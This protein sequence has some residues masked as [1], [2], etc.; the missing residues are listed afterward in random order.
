MID[1]KLIFIVLA[2]G[3]LLPAGSALP[4]SRTS[5]ILTQP[6]LDLGS[7]EEPNVADSGLEYSGIARRSIDLISLDRPSSA[8]SGSGYLD[9]EPLT[10]QQFGVVVG[11]QEPPSVGLEYPGT[12][13]VPSAA[14]FS[15]YILINWISTTGAAKG[16]SQRVGVD[17]NVVLPTGTP[18]CGLDNSNFKLETLSVPPGG[19]EVMGGVGAST[20][21]SCDYIMNIAPIMDYQGNP[22]T[23]GPG[24]Y[25]VVIRYIKDGKE[26]ASKNINFTIGGLTQLPPEMGLQ[27]GSALS[28]MTSTL[29][30]P[31]QRLWLNPQP[32]PPL[33]EDGAMAKLTELKNMLDAG[34]ITQGEYDTKKAE[35]LASM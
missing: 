14:K 18:I 3:L 15:P 17:F 12:F 28:G 20:S 31:R 23:W 24:E 9:I 16:N 25:I 7:E 22:Y 32:E 27:T 34:L 35:I 10:G 6:A 26:L 29:E 11:S 2:I 19:A 4:P 5:Q 30:N 13:S 8:D 33:P 21:P 1:T